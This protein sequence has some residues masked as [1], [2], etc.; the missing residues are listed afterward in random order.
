[1]PQYLPER[2][3]AIFEN[4]ANK[5]IISEINDS[6]AKLFLFPEIVKSEVLIDEFDEVLAGLNKF[7]WLIF[8]DVYAADSFI[9][10]L[11]KMGFDPF[12]MDSSQ[13]C[14]I[15]ESVA[16]RL[17]F[18]Q[19]HSDIITQSIK[20]AEVIKALESYVSGIEKLA[21]LKFLVLKEQSVVL[22]ITRLLC[23]LKAMVAEVPVYVVRNEPEES[24][25][26]LKALLKGGAVDEFI[27]S[28]PSELLDL[29]NLFQNE[30]LG[31]L[32]DG[33]TFTPLNEQTEQAITEYRLNNK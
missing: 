5:R 8:T 2:A 18:S 1:M 32:L 33:I 9:T 17:R 24:V 11:G 12:D 22:G 15:G 23:E 26:K 16:D 31:E 27:L 21:G 4:T 29:S 14:S 10:L 25:T 20:P 19:V 13:I 3:Y 6:G 30:V 28:S 7:D